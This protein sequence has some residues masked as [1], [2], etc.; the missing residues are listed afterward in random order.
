MSPHGL[1]ESHNTLLGTGD[2]ALDHDE[3]VVNLTIADEA[4][5]T[6]KMIESAIANASQRRITEKK[7]TE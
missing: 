1:T 2:R 7:L 6:V 3:V 4:T 5:E